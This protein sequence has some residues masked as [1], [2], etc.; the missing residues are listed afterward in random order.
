M[1]PL[2]CWSSKGAFYIFAA[3]IKNTNEANKAGGARHKAVCITQMSMPS[4]DRTL[5]W[6]YLDSPGAYIVKTLTTVSFE[7][8]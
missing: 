5:G 2:L 6:P 8:S 4:S 3:A 1:C 7:C